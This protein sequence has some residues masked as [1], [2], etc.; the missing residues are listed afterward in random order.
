M[1]HLRLQLLLVLTTM[2]MFLIT[3]WANEALFRRFEYAEG[4][5]WVYLPAGVRLLSTML[6]AEAGAVGLLLV[7]WGVSFFYM[8]P[9]DHTRAFVGGLLATAAPYGVYRMAQH[10]MG[11]RKSLHNLTASR[12]LVCSVAYAIA[13][14]LLHHVWFY[15]HGDSQNLVDGFLVMFTGDLVGTLLVIYTGKCLLSL[16]AWWQQKHQLAV[17]NR[18]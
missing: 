13:S 14:P 6:F 4:I 5:N 3:L 1:K 15:L 2:L 17:F 9:H 12:L 11:L 10:W 8:F 7:S 18:L 16:H